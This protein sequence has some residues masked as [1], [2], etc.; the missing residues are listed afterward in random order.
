MFKEHGL[1][2]RLRA[3]MT[4]AQCEA[5]LLRIGNGPSLHTHCSDRSP[6]CG[7][8]YIS[9]ATLANPSMVLEEIAGDRILIAANLAAGRPK[10]YSGIPVVQARGPL[11]NG[12][13]P[14]KDNHTLSEISI[15]ATAG[16]SFFDAGVD[17]SVLAH[18]CSS[19][20]IESVQF[21]GPMPG[22]VFKR[23]A[24]GLGYYDDTLCVG[25]L[26]HDCMLVD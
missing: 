1:R 23:G 3:Y 9:F 4:G 8:W 24:Q 16:T 10:H 6:L 13:P 5:C 17:A 11:P 12:A 20:F 7:H 14:W 25:T 26:L 15:D 18:E 19:R 2:P 21:N 22:R